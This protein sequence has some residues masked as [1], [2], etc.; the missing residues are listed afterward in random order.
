MGVEVSIELLRPGFYPAGGGRIHVSITPAARLVR[1]D[2]EQRGEIVSRHGRAVVANLAYTIAQR[3]ARHAAE[4]LEWS[5]DSVDAHTLTGS[6]GPGNAV[7]VFVGAENVTNVFTTFGARG[8]TAEKVA[9]DVAL[10]AKRYI[11]SGAAVDEHLA[12][13]L[14]LPLA[15]GA[16]GCF[17]TTPL[18]LHAT[19][20]IE[21]IRQFVDVSI[22]VQVISNGVTRVMVEPVIRG[23]QP[24][25]GVN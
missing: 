5:P 7:S 1:L 2:L 3:E 16:G 18:S 12:D 9:H 25:N 11:N 17:T 22:D 19:T 24:Q 23:F 10:Q 13:Q 4:V 21:V 14:L 8:V 20:N 6:T 15:V